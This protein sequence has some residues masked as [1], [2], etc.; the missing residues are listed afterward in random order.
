MNDERPKSVVIKLGAERPNVEV[1]QAGAGAPLFF[2]HGAGGVGEWG[3]LLPLLAQ[4]FHVSAPLLPGF[5]QSDG[6]EH[7]EDVLDLVLHHFDV[8]EALGLQRPYVVGESMGGWLA[9][10]MAALRPDKIGRLALL[11]PLGLWRDDAPVAD[12][13]GMM[14]HEMVPYLFHDTS[15]AAAQAMLGLRELVSDKDDRSQAQIETLLELAR[16]ARTAAKFLFPIPENGLERRLWRVT[17]PTLVVWGNEDRF[18]PPLY[19]EIFAKK[20]ASAWLV[21]IPSAGHLVGLEQ[22]QA[23]ACAITDW[24]RPN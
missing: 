14:S 20:I 15:C 7:L 5:G 3:G 16:G 1:L 23:C 11:A 19:A 21:K 17:A 8:M 9:A 4:S 22:P 13:F 2:L 18:A 12:M 10:E 24:G 6:L